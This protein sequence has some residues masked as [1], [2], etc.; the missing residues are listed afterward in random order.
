MT[1]NHDLNKF[2]SSLYSYSSENVTAESETAKKKKLRGLLL[3]SAVAFVLIAIFAYALFMLLSYSKETDENASAY[4]EIRP[5]PKAYD[6]EVAPAT[7]LPEPMPM[8]N[9]MQTYNTNGSYPQYIDDP[10]PANEAQRRRSYYKNYL[11]FRASYDN[12]FAWVYVSHTNMDYPVMKELSDGYY[13][14]H[15]YKGDTSSSGSIFT[16]MRTSDDY[17]SNRNVIIHGHC[18]KNG[19]M[20]RTLKTFMESA[21]RNTLAKDMV[22]EIYRPEGL[23]IYSVLT[24]YRDDKGT[25]MRVS[26]ADD[27]DY[28]KWLKT[29]VSNNKLSVSDKYDYGTKIV[30]LVT[31]ANVS[32]NEDERYVLQCALKSFIP[33]DSLK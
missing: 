32:S 19:S 11:N 23:Y 8:Y 15:N 10:V 25:F 5:N 18:M 28:Y 31:C 29:A 30:T 27:D 22:V 26:F 16:D 14:T 13:L 7:P 2:D 4:E 9:L 6:S 33:G 3:T 17:L 24:G 21:N 12:A 1:E 20:F